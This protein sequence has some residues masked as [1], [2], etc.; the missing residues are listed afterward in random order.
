[1]YKSTRISKQSVGR[2][3]L[4]SSYHIFYLYL[5]L[6]RLSNDASITGV[7]CKST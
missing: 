6:V 7:Q 1:M 4:I 5:C 2:H 3:S